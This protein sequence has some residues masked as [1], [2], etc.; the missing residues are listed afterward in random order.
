VVLVNDRAEGRNEAK[1]AVVIL[2]TDRATFARALRELL[3]A[4]EVVVAFT[5]RALRVRYRQAVLG[6][7]WAV[8]Q[9]LAL[10]GAFVVLTDRAADSDTGVPSAAIT[11]AG[12]VGWQFVSAAVMNGANALVAEAPLIRKAWFPRE[13]PVLAAVL[14]ALVELAIVLGLFV[15]AAP[16]L[17]AR[18]GV[19]TLAAPLVLVALVAS[20][21]GMAVPLAAL[22][23]VFRDVRHALPVGLMLLLLV[24]PVGFAAERISPRWRLAY[25]FVD[26]LVGPLDGLQ[27]TLATGRA[28]HW[29]LLAASTASALALL[30]FGHRWFRRVAPSLPDLV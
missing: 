5:V 17:G 14:A 7:L 20:A 2:A 24:S 3:D 29:D 6:A 11:L 8:L 16:W 22:N 26:P 10:L 15:V 19:G 30:L 1:G 4:R 27:R 25:A 28:P 13:A 9:P 21:L 18:A 12:L 23:A